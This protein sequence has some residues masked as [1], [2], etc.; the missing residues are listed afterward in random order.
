MNRRCS[1]SV[2]IL[3]VGL[4]STATA[5][6]KA[7]NRWAVDR[8]LTLSPQ[9][10][11]H[12]A[13]KYRLLPLS[14]E[15]KDGNAVPIYLRLVHQQSDAA[16]KYWTETPERWNSLPVDRIPLEEARKFLKQQHY[17]LRQLEAGA[18][19]RNA[20]WNYTLD[21]GN[22]I[23]LLLPDVQTMRSYMPMLILQARVAL[24]EGDFTTAAHHLETGFAFCRQI[25]GASFLISDLVAIFGV[26][27]FS[28]VV[29]DFVER[30]DAP[31]LYW[32]LTALPRPFIDLRHGLDLEY[33]MIE[34]Q[35]PELADLDVQRTPAQWDRILRRI[36]TEIQ[37]LA[38]PAKHEV[39]ID[40]SGRFPSGTGPD[41]PAAKS[42]DLPAAQA[43]VSRSR[44]LTA[45][46]VEAMPAAQVL[47][48]YMMNAIRYWRDEYFRIT[49]LNYP[50][51]QEFGFAVVKRLDEAPRSEGN[52]MARLFLPAIP[53]AFERV[54]QM[55]RGLAALRIV[56]ALRLYAAA[57]DGKL[58]QKLD[59]I[60]E[61]PIPDD[62]VTGK[63]FQYSRSDETATLQSEPPPEGSITVGIRYRITIRK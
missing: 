1:W 8:S 42:P 63:P 55:E 51:I 20:E 16:Q 12:P 58:P 24:A 36:R 5:D 35:Y 40:L 28:S 17:F 45:Q 3:A 10:A 34:M 18:R 39:G 23:G 62:P 60:T 54:G 41:D 22:P 37:A 9:A 29:A 56:E 57:H 59:E 33:Q 49:Y 53:R 43:F 32:A 44:K 47:L 30:P 7:P 21:L 14:S 11:P 2:L 31:N 25:G 52:A 4:S 48:M 13:L 6:D 46:Q 19:R 27:R 15:L 38:R 61:V 26:N 50:Q